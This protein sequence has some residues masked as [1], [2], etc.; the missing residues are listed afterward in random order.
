[1]S[2]PN[3]MALLV[4]GGIG[5]AS[6]IAIVR[7]VFA[8]KA[9]RKKMKDEAFAPEVT[10]V[11]FE[12]KRLECS[13]NGKPLVVLFHAHWCR[14]CT[15]LWPTYHKVARDLSASAEFVTID[16]DSERPLARTM[17]VGALPT[18]YVLNGPGDPVDK[19]NGFLRE[20]QLK[21]FLES[22]FKL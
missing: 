11:E 12:A 18:I 9:L 20:A 17:K 16:V 2:L 15:L 5:A 10:A 14:A 8:G 1:M 7:M 3:W 19:S 6:A 22:A 4:A 13:E 21:Q